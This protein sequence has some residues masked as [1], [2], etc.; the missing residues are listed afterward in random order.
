MSRTIAVAIAL[1]HGLCSWCLG[2]L[3]KLG[4]EYMLEAPDQLESMDQFL[5]LTWVAHIVS[6]LYLVLIIVVVTGVGHDAV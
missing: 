6:P 2:P 4:S 1:R 5:R 3:Y